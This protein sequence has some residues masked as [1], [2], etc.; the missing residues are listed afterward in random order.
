MLNFYLKI[1]MTV[2]CLGFFKNKEF[3]NVATFAFPSEFVL[4]PDILVEHI[5]IFVGLFKNRGGRPL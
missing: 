5:K 4:M 3:S 1:M 2:I